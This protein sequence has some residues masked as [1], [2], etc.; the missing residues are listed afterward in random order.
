MCLYVYLS[1]SHALKHARQVLVFCIIIAIL[2][3]CKDLTDNEDGCPTHCT[4]TDATCE[5]ER[6]RG[7]QEC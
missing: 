5:L 1:C 6:H 3:Q 4:G 2:V 7:G